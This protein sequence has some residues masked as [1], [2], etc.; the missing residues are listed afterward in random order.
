MLT[1]FLTIIWRNLTRHSFYSFLTI[2]GLAIGIAAGFLI[3]Q[4][5]YFETSYDTFFEN[6]DD[7]YRVQLNRYNKGELT[8]QWAAGCAGAGLAMREDFP[9]VVDFVNMTKSNAQI[10][11]QKNYFKLDYAYYAG[12]SFFDVFSV[13]LLRGI[14]NTSKKLCPA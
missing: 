11:Y 7:I 12:Q 14:E 6:K 4:Y 9:E 5:V 1:N 10:S 2:S 13:P 3:L 8:T